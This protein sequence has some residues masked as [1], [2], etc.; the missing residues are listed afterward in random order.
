M[1]DFCIP[2]SGSSVDE[3]T[4][5]LFERLN[6]NIKAIYEELGKLSPKQARQNTNLLE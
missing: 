1:M 4:T 5:E 2:I 6:G 3:Q